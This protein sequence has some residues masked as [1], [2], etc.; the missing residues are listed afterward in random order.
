[1]NTVKQVITKRW[2]WILMAALLAFLVY[3][4][5]RLAHSIPFI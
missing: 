1:M 5:P 3:H 2:A 4:A